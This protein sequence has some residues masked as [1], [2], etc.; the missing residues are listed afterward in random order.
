MAP[1]RRRPRL[2]L[3]E[4]RDAPANLTATYSAL[5]RTLTV[6]GTDAANELTIQGDAA[7][8][9]H[10][11][12][13]SAS[14]SING[15][16][17]PF[18][19]PHGV[20]AIVVRMLGGDDTVTFGNADPVRLRRGLT[21]DGGDGTNVLSAADLT[22]GGNL[23]VRNGTN[24]NDVDVDFT[25]LRNLNVGGSLTIQN[26]SGNAATVVARTGPGLSRVAGSVKVVGGAGADT[27]QLKDLNVGGGVTVRGA[28]GHPG[29]SAGVVQ[30]FNEF[31]RQ[32][33]VV[34]GGVSVAFNGGGVQTGFFDVDIGGDVTVSAGPGACV[35]TATGF[36]T[37]QP[38][39]IGGNLTITG[40]GLHHLYLGRDGTE[41]GVVVGRNLTV[42]AGA[43]DD[44]L[45]A[46]RLSVGG[47]TWLSFGDG[48]TA[49]TIDDSAF[50]GT[51]TLTAGAGAD[52]LDIERRASTTG[53]TVFRRGFVAWYGAGGTTVVL[54]GPDDAYQRLTFA[55]SA[56]IHHGPDPSS[57]T[58]YPGVSSPFGPELQFIP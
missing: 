6:V 7:D 44:I 50:N 8:T 23:T 25:N 37:A 40:T 17:G 10:F 42:R 1:Y 28:V 52:T 30:L 34:R 57:L 43:G 4:G 21:V 18:D 5:T 20:E 22:V 15:A 45:V 13:T 2:E 49:V 33:S 36:T 53:A 26:G 58:R 11:T 29:G 38:V 14:D 46:Y 31:N 51:F 19:A 3:L 12:V 39:R 32:R 41:P 48:K 54:G 47:A 56:A 24:P 16:D 55:S 9:T 27:V 35:T